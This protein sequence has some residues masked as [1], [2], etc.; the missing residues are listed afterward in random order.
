MRFEPYKNVADIIFEHES[1]QTHTILKTQ[2]AITKL[3]LFFPHPP[4]GPN[5]LRQSFTFL[6]RSKKREKFGTR[7]EVTGKVT[8]LC[9][10]K[11]QTGKR[12]E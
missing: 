4:Y 2:E 3:R 5:L 6:E 9:D 11:I 12:R 7:E 10:Y 1:V 8:E